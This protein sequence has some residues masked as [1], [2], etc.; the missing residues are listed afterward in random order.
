MNHFMQPGKLY[1]KRFAGDS[2][3][4]SI[5]N[6][7]HFIL[8]QYEIEF[9]HIFMCLEQPS[10]RY[11]P[12]PNPNEDYMRARVMKVLFQDQVLSI[13]LPQTFTEPFS[14]LFEQVENP[15]KPE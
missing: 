10:L 15:N 2:L 4:F 7:E 13:I 12:S 14:V 6:E 11:I 9:D 5:D 8:N 3:S 1:K